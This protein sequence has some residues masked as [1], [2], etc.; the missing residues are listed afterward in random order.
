MKA[1][2]NILLRTLPAW[3]MWNFVNWLPWLKIK[4]SEKA[5]KIIL[6]SPIT[7]LYE[8][9]ISSYTST[10]Q[11]IATKWMQKHVWNSNCLLLSLILKS[12]AKVWNNAFFLTISFYFQ[13]WSYFSQTTLVILACKP[14]YDL[15]YS[16]TISKHM[17]WNCVALTYNIV[18]SEV[19]FYK[20]I[21]TVLIYFVY[22]MS[23]WVM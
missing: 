16:L 2:W 22:W 5:S 13:K 15:I 3:W 1:L 18:N 21:I 23:L 9:E 17:F 19:Y 4:L 7:Y 8:A 6:L 14:T 10:K 11:H 20:Y 12:F